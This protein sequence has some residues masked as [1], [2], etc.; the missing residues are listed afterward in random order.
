MTEVY[1]TELGS[2]P[3]S[4]R[5][6]SSRGVRQPMQPGWLAVLPEASWAG[7]YWLDH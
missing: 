6:F 4:A 2:K 1:R 3:D 7:L 5:F